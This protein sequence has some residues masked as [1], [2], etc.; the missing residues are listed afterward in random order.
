MAHVFD[1]ATT[2][3]RREVWKG[4]VGR[5][6]EDDVSLPDGRRITLGVLH[7][8]GASAI[9]PLLNDGRVVLLRQYRYAIRKTLWEIPAGNLDPGEAPEACALRELKEETGYTAKTLI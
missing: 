4:S 3:A 1:D 8:L 6:G 2:L 9:V 7:H 5:F